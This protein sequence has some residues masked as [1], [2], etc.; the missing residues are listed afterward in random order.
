MEA[1]CV[2]KSTKIIKQVGLKKAYES[3]PGEKEAGKRQIMYS[4]QKRK[5]MQLQ[6]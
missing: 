6:K 3:K 4:K 5:K 1:D 2:L